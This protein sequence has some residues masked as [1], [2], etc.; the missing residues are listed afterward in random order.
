MTVV[1]GFP[2]RRDVSGVLELGATLAAARGEDLLVVAVV[3]PRWS[4]PS[5]ARVDAEFADWAEAQGRAAEQEA[6]ASLAGLPVAGTADIRT[7]ADRSAAA[8]LT[9]I[10]DDVGAS[11]IVVGSSEDGDDG[12]ILLGSTGDR[13]VHSSRMPVALAPRGYAAPAGGLTR[14][15]CAVAGHAGDAALVE[16]ARDLARGAEVPL[17]LVTFAVRLDNMYPAEVGYD[18]EDDVAAAVGEQAGECVAALRRSG[19]VGADVE[20]V[21]GL[22]RG[23]RAA[24]ESVAW[25]AGELLVIGTNPR[26]SL[27]RVF[28]GSSATKIVRHSPVPVLVAPEPDR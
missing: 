28:L 3:P 24:L 15:T 1:V 14:V 8:A 23:W 26:G 19:V 6:A 17:R 5:M 20:A 2:P 9:R 21:V 25:D 27:A 7:V 4:V 10:A 13:L 16:R 11:A 12:R 18:A 22:G